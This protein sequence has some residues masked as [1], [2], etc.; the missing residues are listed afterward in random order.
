M[1]LGASTAV[2]HDKPRTEALAVPRELPDVL[3]PHGAAHSAL[4]GGTTL[5]IEKD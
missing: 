5:T 1:K 3:L 4:D 2:L